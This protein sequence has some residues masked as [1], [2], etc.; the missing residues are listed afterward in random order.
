MN[1]GATFV[2]EA[3]SS[4]NFVKFLNSRSAI[5]FPMMFPMGPFR[6]STRLESRRQSVEITFLQRCLS[7]HYLPLLI[8][9]RTT[10]VGQPDGCSVI[11]HG[12]SRLASNSSPPFWQLWFL[13]EKL[14]DIRDSHRQFP[15]NFLFYFIII[16]LF[17]LLK[18]F[19]FPT[20]K[21]NL[22]NERKVFRNLTVTQFHYES[23]ASLSM[24]VSRFPYRIF[25]MRFSL[26]LA[27]FC[28]KNKQKYPYSFSGRKALKSSGQGEPIFLL[29][30]A[31]I[32]YFFVMFLFGR[33]I[34]FLSFWFRISIRDQRTSSQSIY[35]LGREF[36]VLFLFFRLTQSLCCQESN[37]HPKSA[38]KF[39]KKG[40][41][42]LFIYSSNVYPRLPV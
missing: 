40:D 31:N 21:K 1:R 16:I 36:I 2:Q 23:S 32:R 5:I 14:Y 6:T 8:L 19:Y 42:C 33:Q 3:A 28:N 17:S 10:R 15:T 24:C 22:L 41:G 29:L 26:A 35:T 25:R 7:F 12:S 34:L 11:R 38:L 9:Y 30:L 39:Y 13:R 4:F 18:L 20:K 27:Q 37:P